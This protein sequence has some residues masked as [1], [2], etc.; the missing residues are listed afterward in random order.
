MSIKD[1]L[2]RIDYNIKHLSKGNPGRDLKKLKL[3]K[4]VLEKELSKSKLPDKETL[5]TYNIEKLIRL[6]W[7]YLTSKLNIDNFKKKTTDINNSENRPRYSKLI[8]K[9]VMLEKL[10]ERQE[11]T[12]KKIS[13]PKILEISLDYKRKEENKQGRL[14]NGVKK[15]EN[16]LKSEEMLEKKALNKLT[17]GKYS[18]LEKQKIQLNNMICEFKEERRILENKLQLTSKIYFIQ[19]R[20]LNKK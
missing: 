6:R 7:E 14:K 9:A 5:E 1:S 12:V 4:K 13:K 17:K 18:Y 3:E 2:E 10:I 8:H 19:S 15:L 11:A 20:K 16:L